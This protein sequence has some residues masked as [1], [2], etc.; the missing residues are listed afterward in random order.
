EREISA[1]FSIAP[2][3]LRITMTGAN[4]DDIKLIL[5][6]VREAYLK[7]VVDAD[8]KAKLNHLE[9]VKKVRDRYDEMLSGKRKV[10]ANILEM[11]GGKNAKMVAAKQEDAR[12][13]ANSLRSQLAKARSDVIQAKAEVAALQARLKATEASD[14]P[15]ELVDQDLQKDVRV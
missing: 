8:Y 10:R 9:Q 2:E 7:E 12:D 6:A 3:T 1:D 5:N 14:V 4:P 15:E 13:Q 11:L